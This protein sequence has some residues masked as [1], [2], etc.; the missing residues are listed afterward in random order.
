MWDYYDDWASATEENNWVGADNRRGLVRFLKRDILNKIESEGQAIEMCNLYLNHIKDRICGHYK[1]KT[2]EDLLN[3]IIL[4]MSS[5]LF[6]HTHNRTTTSL[7]L[8]GGQGTG[9]GVFASWF[10]ELFGGS[11]HYFYHVTNSQYM[12]KQFNKLMENRLLVFG[13]E[14]LFVGDKRD[15][16]ILKTMQTEK[17]QQIEPK[18]INAYI[19][20]NFRRFIFA[21]NFEVAIYKEK[22]DRRNQLVNR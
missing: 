9:K 13:D 10:G 11:Q 21:S 5:C 7:I 8:C 16:Q 4:W 14:T 22:D 18:N 19:A 6:Q 3:Y 20:P 15:Q 1:G 17:S 12:T 2:H